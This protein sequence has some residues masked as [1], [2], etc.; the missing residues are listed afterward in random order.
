[1]D[2][3]AKYLSDGTP[4]PRTYAEIPTADPR[5]V[6]WIDKMGGKRLFFDRTGP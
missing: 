5:K 2:S 4:P 6:K 3:A 1:M